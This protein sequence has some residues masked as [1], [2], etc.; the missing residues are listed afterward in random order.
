M[1]KPLTVSVMRA[2]AAA[3]P[4]PLVVRAG[5]RLNYD[6]ADKANSER[7]KNKW[8][9][10]LWCTG[11]NGIQAWVPE[12]YV[13]VEKNSCVLLKDYDSTELTV[14]EGDTLLAHFEVGGWLWCSTSG[15]LEGWVPKENTTP[16]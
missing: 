7:S 4:T 8:P 14:S 16:A 9:E 1:S 11:G 12:D 15:G 3:Y 2:Y 5:E 13:R 10:W 6:S